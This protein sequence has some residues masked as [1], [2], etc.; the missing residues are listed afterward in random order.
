MR[1][2]QDFKYDENG[3]KIPDS[4]EDALFIYG[5]DTQ[6]INC[7]ENESKAVYKQILW[8]DQNGDGE[9]ELLIEY[10]DNTRIT[11]TWEQLLEENET[12]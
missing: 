4:L 3:E 2:A 5:E 11:Y 6:I 10:E 1:Y 7:L 8:Q 12:P 9:K